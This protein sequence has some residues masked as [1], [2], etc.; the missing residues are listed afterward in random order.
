MATTLEAM[1]EV[2]LPER[3]NIDERFLGRQVAEGNG[4]RT[5]IVADDSTYS[6]AEVDDRARAYGVAL[7]QMGVRPEERVVLALRDGVDYV[8]ALF[9]I[10]RIGAVAVMVN[11]DLPVGSVKTTLDRSRPSVALVEAGVAGVV[12]EAMTQATW[13]ATELVSVGGDYAGHRTFED[14]DTSGQCD[15]FDTHRDDPAIWLFSGGTTG[16]PKVVPQTH[17]SFANT[18]ALYT[19]AVGYRSDDITLAVPKLFFGYATGAN[20]FFPFSVGGTSVLFAERPTPAVLFEK[21]ERH[22]PTILIHVPSA[23]S[24]MLSHPGGGDLSSVR[25]ATS[26]GEA[27]PESLYRAWKSRFGVEILDGLGTAEMWHIFVTNTPGDVKPG[28]LGKVVPGFELSARDADGRQVDIGE[29]GQ[30]WVTGDSRGLGYW[31]DAD[32][33]AEAF[34]GE[35]VAAGDLISIDPDGYVTHRGRADDAVKVKGKWFRPQELESC[36]L[37]HPSVEAA[38]SL[39]LEDEEGLFRPVAFVTTSSPTTEAEIQEWV[40][41]RLEPYKHPRRVV[42]VDEMPLTHLGKV[43]RGG[44]KRLLD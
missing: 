18:T 19:R 8:G 26:A 13:S 36:L 10:L 38:A 7:R 32:A 25:F 2:D 37:E 21:I 16:I 29:I 33:T 15:R 40:L 12:A 43:D 3:L 24:Q 31:Q 5:A 30:L 14:L 11:P 27:L 34:R 20:L 4:D 23:I 22:R 9:G 44:L 39:A 35:W 1:G 42:F 41:A 28:T 6:Y 17:R